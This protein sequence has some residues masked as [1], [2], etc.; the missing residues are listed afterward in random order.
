MERPK[1]V[2]G[3]RSLCFVFFAFWSCILMASETL[4]NLSLSVKFTLKKKIEHPYPELSVSEADASG[5]W[6]CSRHLIWSFHD[7]FISLNTSE[8]P[9]SGY[10]ELGGPGVLCVSSGAGSGELGDPCLPLSS[11]TV[12]ITGQHQRAAQRFLPHFVQNHY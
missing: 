9:V 8:R 3:A 6:S 4:L 5:S 11:V 7:V 2:C 10:C 12:N 1:C